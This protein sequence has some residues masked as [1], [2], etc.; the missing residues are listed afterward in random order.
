[1]TPIDCQTTGAE[2]TTY[3]AVLCWGGRLAIAAMVTAYL[4]YLTGISTPR[5]AP[6]EVQ[7]AWH[8]SHIEFART[9]G[10]PTGWG[11]LAELHHADM[12]AMAG[13][14]LVPL[15]SLLGVAALV[16]GC[17]RRR[18]W[19]FGGVCVAFVLLVVGT[20]LVGTGGH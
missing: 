19:L 2:Q 20:A 8:L 9:T 10:V 18:E 5:L 13:L 15:V 1:M 4:A 17:V 3:A 16:P 11:F 12:G 14:C 7:A 6:A